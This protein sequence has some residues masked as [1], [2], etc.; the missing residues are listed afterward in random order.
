L[1]RIGVAEPIL[2]KTRALDSQAGSELH[3]VLL[4][5]SPSVRAAENFLDRDGFRLLLI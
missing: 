2:I 4:Q 1:P 5:R 3:I